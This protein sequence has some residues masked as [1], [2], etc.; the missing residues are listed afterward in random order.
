MK[1]D[2]RAEEGNDFAAMKKFRKTRDFKES[3]F[4]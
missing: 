4:T 1:I 2:Q 3:A